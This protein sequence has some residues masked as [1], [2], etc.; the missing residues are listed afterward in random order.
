MDAFRAG[1]PDHVDPFLFGIQARLKKPADMDAVRDE[2][3]ATVNSFRETKVP[4]G[5]LE[6]VKRHLRYQFALSLNS[7]EAIAGVTARF[8]ALRRTPETINRIYELY[9]RVTPD[10]IRN[11]A[12]KYLVDQGRT[13]VTLTSGGAQ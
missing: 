7:S 12:R 11:V 2:I 3:L 5:K 9:G 8:V 10:D 1:N 13:I 4:A 6:A